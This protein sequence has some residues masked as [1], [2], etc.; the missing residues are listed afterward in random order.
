[1]TVY[2]KDRNEQLD[3]GYK[4]QGLEGLDCRSFCFLRLEGTTFQ[5]HGCVCQLGSCLKLWFQDFYGDFN[6]WVH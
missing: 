5:I 2:Q 1:M 4:G 3:E 6:M